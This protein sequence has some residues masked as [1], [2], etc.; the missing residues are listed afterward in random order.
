MK[1]S[2]FIVMCLVCALFVA[3][4]TSA[5]TLGLDYLVGTVEPGT[6]S[7]ASDVFAY[8]TNL[9]NFWNTGTDPSNF[10]AGPP[11]TGND[12]FLSDPPTTGS[13]VPASL[14]DAIGPGVSSL[15]VIGL[16]LTGYTYLY[17]KFGQDGAL[18]YLG[19]DFSSID[20]FSPAWGPFSGPQGFELSHVTL[21]NLVTT[22]VP[23]AGVL[24]LFGTGL[25]GLVGY[26]RV[27]RMK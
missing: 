21:F 20:G 25:I 6:P 24:I 27:R 12:Y 13:L 15:S 14:P 19:G 10:D 17:A 18:Y 2:V 7:G 11:P 8:T 9:I 5:A 16:D 26:R 1:R 22:Q 4:P 3:G 23:E